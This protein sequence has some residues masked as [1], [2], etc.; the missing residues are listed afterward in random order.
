[1]WGFERIFILTGDVP[2][3]FT[4]SLEKQKKITPNII[5]YVVSKLIITLTDL[6]HLKGW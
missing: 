2:S 5:I 1:M 4:F 6:F 3:A